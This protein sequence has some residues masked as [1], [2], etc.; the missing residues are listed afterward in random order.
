MYEHLGC[1]PPLH[2]VLKASGIQQ[3][4]TLYLGQRGF[5]ILRAPVLRTVA[6]VRGVGG[7]S[8]LFGIGVCGCEIRV[9]WVVLILAKLFELSHP[10]GTRSYRDTGFPVWHFKGVDNRGVEIH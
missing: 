9:V 5:R 2:H 10:A 1:L 4:Y 6:R 3:T 7:G 8:D